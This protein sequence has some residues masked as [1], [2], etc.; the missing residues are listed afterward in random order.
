[1]KK[2]F[3]AAAI[4]AGFV[5]AFILLGVL[6]DLTNRELARRCAEANGVF[7]QAPLPLASTC[8]VTVTPRTTAR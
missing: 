4:V 7:A 8:T 1:M 5:V 3:K 2:T 6:M